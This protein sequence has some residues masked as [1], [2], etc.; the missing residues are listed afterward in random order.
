MVTHLSRSAW[1]KKGPR[2]ALTPLAIAD[3]KGI[4]LHWPGTTGPIGDPGTK[5]I[6]ARLEGYRAYHT[7]GAPIGH[8][9]ND[10]AYN[11]AVD[12]A[13]RVWDLRGVAYQSAANGD[14]TVNR[15]YVAIL[16]LVGPGEAPT[17]AAIEGVKYARG[18]VL[19]RF[20]KAA[21]VKGHQD[22]RP[23]PTDCPGKLIEGLIRIDAFTERENPVSRDDARPVVT[24][25]RV[26][27]RGATGKDVEALQ[28]RLNVLRNPD[29][30]VDGDYGPITEK[31]VKAFQRAKFPLAPWQWD[32]I[33]GRKTAGK[34]GFAFKA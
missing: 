34:L 30:R 13:G 24:L 22:V 21:L 31:A 11:L 18:M 19:N 29:I 16:V 32:G 3:V 10:I 15:Q 28:R 6:A 33:V 23:D 14:Q 2:R 5:G 20:P 1:T 8:G 7:A 4:A 26:L 25:K 17:K 9:W 12:Q 27:R